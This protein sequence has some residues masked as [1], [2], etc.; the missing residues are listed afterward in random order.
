MHDFVVVE[1]IHLLAGFALELERVHAALDHEGERQI[2]L[3]RQLHAVE[4]GRLGGLEVAGFHEAT[5]G[6]QRQALHA[7]L[8]IARRPGA[9]H[10]HARAALQLAD[11]A[12]GVVVRGVAFEERCLLP[13]A[14]VSVGQRLVEVGRERHRRQGGVRHVDGGALGGT[15]EASRAHRVPAAAAAAARV[16]L[17]GSRHAGA[18]VQVTELPRAA[19]GRSNTGVM[20]A[21]A[22]NLGPVAAGSGTLGMLS[23]SVT[24]FDKLGPS[25]CETAEGRDEQRQ[26]QCQAAGAAHQQRVEHRGHTE[27]V[28]HDRAKVAKFSAALRA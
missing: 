6:Q 2:I 28:H 26:R 24:A 16:R 8:R 11:L 7:A 15:D 14:R 21:T 19:A 18:G 10:G 13:C 4:R 1:R 22:P 9:D 5:A 25:R 20:L 23:S 17:C 3:L 12:H 27:A